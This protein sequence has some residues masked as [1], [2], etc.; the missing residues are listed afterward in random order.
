MLHP[1]KKLKAVNEVGPTFN[2]QPNETRNKLHTKSVNSINKLDCLISKNKNKYK[3]T[4]LDLI[5]QTTRKNGTPITV[6][7]VYDPLDQ[8][9]IIKENLLILIDSG[10]LHSM[11]K[12]SLVIKY[13]D[14]FFKQSKAS[15]KTAAGMFKS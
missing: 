6:A 12:A 4:S 7:S 9:K 3:L 11:A 14:S 13:K 5:N 8:T 15:Y 2:K 1:K 10:A